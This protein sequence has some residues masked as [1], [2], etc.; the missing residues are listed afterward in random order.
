MQSLTQPPTLEP[1]SMPCPKH[2]PFCN[3]DRLAASIHGETEPGF[4]WMMHS[5]TEDSEATMA[6]LFAEHNYR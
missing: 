6:R 2:C 1:Y 3:A 5:A 4:E